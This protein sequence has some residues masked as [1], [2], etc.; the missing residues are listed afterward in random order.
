MEEPVLGNFP[1]EI[2]RA[3]IMKCTVREWFRV[4]TVLLMARAIPTMVV[5]NATLLEKLLEKYMDEDGVWLA[6]Q[7]GKKGHHR[8]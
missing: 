4:T 8:Q 2:L 3:F 5:P 1:G 7:R 6:K